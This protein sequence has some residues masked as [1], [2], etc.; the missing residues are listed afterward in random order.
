MRKVIIHTVD[1][2]KQGAKI[3]TQIKLPKTVKR[4]KRIKA[5]SLG[6]NSLTITPYPSDPGISAPLYVPTI[7][8]AGWLWLR[9]PEKRDVFYADTIHHAPLTNPTYEISDA[10]I[11]ANPTWWF[12]GTEKAFFRVDVPIEDT[13]IECY[14]ED[15]STFGPVNYKVN[16]YLE[17]EL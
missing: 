12:S 16:I 17:L 1:V 6:V 4:V 15:R 9:I 5:T 8:Q 3:Q 13:L 14:Y 10:G 2:T 11:D 7:G